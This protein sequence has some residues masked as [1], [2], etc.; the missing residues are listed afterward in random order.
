[1]TGN[2]NFNKEKFC[3]LNIVPT[4]YYIPLKI[5]EKYSGPPKYFCEI[6][7]ITKNTC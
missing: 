6:Y 1:M 4:A 7:I 2:T 5:V 3:S